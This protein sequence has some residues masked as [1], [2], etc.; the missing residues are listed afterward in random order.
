[1]SRP[2][3][4]P[5]P[6]LVLG[7]AVIL[8]AAGCGLHAVASVSTPAPVKLG[9]VVPVAGPG[10]AEGTR[11]QQAV[12]LAVEQRNARGGAA[13]RPVELV[14][15]DDHTPGAGA[16]AAQ[17]LALDPAVLAVAGHPD[18]L[19]GAAA[20]P[21][22][23][24]RGLAAALLGP[25]DGARTDP[26]PWLL[27][28]APDH[29]ALARAAVQFVAETLRATTVA[30][31]AGPDPRDDQQAGAL[32]FFAQ[33]AGLCLVHT[34]ALFP[35]STNYADAVARLAAAQPDVLLI[36]AAMPSAPTFWQEASGT[37]RAAVFTGVPAGS[38]PEF[39]TV[40]AGSAH[41]AYLPAVQPQNGEQP[42][43]RAAVTAY[44]DRW[45]AAPDGA[46]L[47]AYDAAGM[48]LEAMDRALRRSPRDPRAAVGEE[49]RGLRS[50]GGITGLLH[51]NEEGRMEG[52]GATFRPA[53]P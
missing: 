14:V 52:A 27:R 15:H 1:M 39:A 53:A 41:R 25:V 20:L 48:L 50:F 2:I 11:L 38:A 32:R 5:A 51:F 10:Q 3:R 16:Q 19:S 49:L 45:G 9:L 46:S 33:A 43:L 13:G 21:V 24:D 17:R 8:V 22:Y 29:E 34:E 37:A 23:R 12:R 6:V 36:A 26:Q 4:R 7:L 42:D 35:A 31:V 30:V 18:G 44:R 47:L 28:L 40:A